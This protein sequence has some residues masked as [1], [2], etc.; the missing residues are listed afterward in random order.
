MDF[1]EHATFNDII[2]IAIIPFTKYN[3]FFMTD[4][5]SGFNPKN[6]P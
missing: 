3:D 2:T 6:V 1:L 4:G 5:F